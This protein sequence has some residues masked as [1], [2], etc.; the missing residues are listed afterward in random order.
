M[1]YQKSVMVDGSVPGYPQAD[2]TL[3]PSTIHRWITTLGRFGQTCR[4]AISLLLQEK[5]ASSICR[6]LARLIVPQRKYKTG[7]RK[8]QLI[9]S[10][11]LVVIEAIFQATFKRSIFTKL[12][13]RCAF[14]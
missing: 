3:S 11:H 4:T 1:T 13:T 12:A 2:A 8:K 14:G 5:P 10:R 7:N 6:E 9:G